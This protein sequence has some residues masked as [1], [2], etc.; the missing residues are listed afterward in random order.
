[1]AVVP[2]CSP[3]LCATAAGQQPLLSSLQIADITGMII[4]GYSIPLVPTS[5]QAVIV[6]EA[7]KTVAA[8]LE[9]E[10]DVASSKFTEHFQTAL[11]EGLTDALMDELVS[12]LNG[13]LDLPLLN[14]ESE[15]N[16]LR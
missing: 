13:V 6:G 7:V 12:D 5:L 2:R 11:E 9:E 10:P 4:D 15:E 3:V 16:L 1:L 8:K 14:E